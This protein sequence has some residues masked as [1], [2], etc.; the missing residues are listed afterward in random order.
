[1]RCILSAV[2]LAR[3]V[4]IWGPQDLVGNYRSKN[5]VGG[6]GEH[7]FRTAF[8]CPSISSFCPSLIG[9]QWDP[10]PFLNSNPS[11]QRPRRVCVCVY[12]YI[13]IYLRLSNGILDK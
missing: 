4:S 6:R 5:L 8:S 3:A 1:M 2:N 7:A 10:V 12:A 9:S 11:F 13:Y